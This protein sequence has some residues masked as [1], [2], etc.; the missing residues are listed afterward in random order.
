MNIL[1]SRIDKL[2]ALRGVAV[3]G[4]LIMNIIWFVIPEK[5]VEDLGVQVAKV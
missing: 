5:A 4:I 3:L 1:S 2:V